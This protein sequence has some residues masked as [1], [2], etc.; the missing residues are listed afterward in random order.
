[1]EKIV[2]GKREYEEMSDVFSR[3]P[4]II[5]NLLVVN[6]P[7]NAL[8]SQHIDRSITVW[9]HNVYQ[10]RLTQTSLNA[11]VAPKPIAAIAAA[12]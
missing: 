10:F 3:R 6:K 8:V 12:A 5:K 9:Q 1:M 4:L 11:G 2:T 7:E